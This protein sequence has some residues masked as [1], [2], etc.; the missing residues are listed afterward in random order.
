[1]NHPVFELRSTASA[2]AKRRNGKRY[3]NLILFLIASTAIVF[4][5]LISW[6]QTTAL[7]SLQRRNDLPVGNDVPIV[8][9]PALP[10]EPLRFIAVVGMYHSGTTA[11]WN[12]IQSNEKVAADKGIDLHAYVS[13]FGGYPPCGVSLLF[14]STVDMSVTMG[15][16]SEIVRHSSFD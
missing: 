13:G 16:S 7:A 12:S 1:M 10:P 9:P 4:S 5:A 11:M 6:Y 3:W 15:N 8:D 2:A 14:D